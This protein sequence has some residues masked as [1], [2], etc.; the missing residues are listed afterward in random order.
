[1]TNI[2]VSQR[3]NGNAVFFMMSI[4]T[5]EKK[6]TPPDVLIQLFVFVNSG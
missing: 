6:S 1:M 4:N 5:G 2:V 3:K